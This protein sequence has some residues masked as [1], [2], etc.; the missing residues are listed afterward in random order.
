MTNELTILKPCP[1]CGGKVEHIDDT[2]DSE[3]G[4]TREKHF[5]HCLGCSATSDTFDCRQWAADAWNLRSEYSE[6]KEEV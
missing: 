6:T 4:S 3:F 1:F 2:P 5:I